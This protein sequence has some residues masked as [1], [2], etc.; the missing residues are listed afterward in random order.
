MYIKVIC[1]FLVI[2][3]LLKNFVETRKFVYLFISSDYFCTAYRSLLP[4]ILS[5]LQLLYEDSI[6]SQNEPVIKKF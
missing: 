2:Q 3:I 6:Y 4:K 5:F 1:T